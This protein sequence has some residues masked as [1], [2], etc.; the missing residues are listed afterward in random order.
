MAN[1]LQNTGKTKEIRSSEKVET[2]CG[3]MRDFFTKRCAICLHL[4]Y[5]I[6]EVNIQKKYWARYCKKKFR[7]K[8]SSGI[9]I[10][11][12]LVSDVT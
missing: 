4:I 7:V 6:P 8:F 3:I 10:G 12:H 9:Y 5:S 1:C 11:A 2:H